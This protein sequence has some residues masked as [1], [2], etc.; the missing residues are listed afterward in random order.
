MRQSILRATSICLIALSTSPVG[1]GAPPTAPKPRIP[2]IHVGEVVAEIRTVATAANGLPSDDVSSVALTPTGEI[3]AGTARGLARFEGGK[4]SPVG[5]LAAPVNLL[6][7]IQGGVY[8]AAGGKLW[9]VRGDRAEGIAS[10][11]GTDSTN[12][13]RSLTASD[14]PNGHTVWLGT[15]SGLFQM[16]KTEFVPVAS[17]TDLL[18]KD[19]EVRQ[20]AIAANDRVAIAAAGGLFVRESS[21]AWDRLNPIEGARSWLPR[22]VRGVAFDS[23]G[24]LWFASPGGVGCL[25]GGKWS[26]YTGEDGLPYNDFTTVAAGSDGTVWFGTR[27]GAIRFDGKIWNYRQ[28]RR[29]LPDDRVRAIALSPSGDAWFATAKGLG[30]IE[31][32]PTTLADKAAFFEAMIDKYHRRTPYGY[33]GSVA[34]SQPGDVSHTTQYDDDNDGL[35]TGMYGAGECFAYAATHDPIAKKRA[36]AAF[37]ALRF[38]SQV[39]QG[40]E[41][42][43]PKG[44]PARSIRPTSDSD[45]NQAYS[46]EIDQRELRRDPLHK[47]IKPRWPKSADGKWYW[48]CDTSSDELDGHYFLYACYYDLV[49]ETEEERQPAR[50]LIAAV[51]DH[52]LEHDFNLIDHDGKPTR[53]ARFGPNTLNQLAWSEGRGL[54]SLSTLSYLAVAAHATGEKRFRDAFQNLAHHH[55][56]LANIMTAKVQTGPST[57]N[58]SDDEMAFMCYFNLLR[59]GT[60]PEVRRAATISLRRYWSLEEPEHSPL[61][62]FIFAASYD[63]IGRFERRAPS[64]CLAEGVDFLNRYPL[65][66]C[67]WGFKNSHRLDVVH[68]PGFGGRRRLPRGELRTR[69]VVPIDERFIERWNYD[70]WTLDETRTGRTLADGAS[71]LLPYY[72][73]RYFGFLVEDAPQNGASTRLSLS[74]NGR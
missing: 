42:P 62:N 38:L 59:Y 48:K 8:A 32:R 72:I 57:G 24:D 52:L 67:D 4:W 28:G 35:W 54:N 69:G 33:V 12:E 30:R 15:R 11:P 25:K 23:K 53:W 2:G 56:Y 31:R 58:Q 22:D 14:G 17:L 68:M 9:L 13:L 36:K 45:P 49:A 61:F 26:L 20:I 66:R 18:G 16:S 3:Y 1:F 37:E 50:E 63:G 10:L 65:D 70:P 71:F 47:V 39:T 34:L 27:I 5:V 6:A 29:W 19:K 60:D 74:D 55:A 40:G 73:G 64:T 43:A 7:P 44:F 46:D 41:H 21:G 51:T